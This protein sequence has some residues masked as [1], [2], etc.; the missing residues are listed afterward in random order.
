M[1]KA[2]RTLVLCLALALISPIIGCG[3]PTAVSPEM[4]KNMLKIRGYKF[5]TEDFFRGIKSEDT[6]VINGFL[7]AGMNPNSKNKD[8]MTALTYALQNTGIKTIRVLARKADIN[9]KD[10][11]DNG[12][13]H[14][15]ISRGNDEAVA[16]LLDANADVNV[17]GK[18][19]RVTNQS[20]LFAAILADNSELIEKLLKK[21]ADPN[22]ADSE[23]AF[24]LSEACVRNGATV[25]I[26]KLLIEGGAEVNKVEKNGASSLTYAAQN[27]GIDVET[28]KAIVE[29]LL[30]NGADK[31]LRD[32]TGKTALDW[33]KEIGHTEMVEILK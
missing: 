6:A 14:L 9:L 25:K 10:D 24:P 4:S 26:V 16:F 17:T 33:A 29:L 32:K 5:T 1:D 30:K 22:I 8:G 23:S 18:D 20:P 3:G 7:D 19:G 13:L 21:G 11:L 12:P 2:L 27:S 28:R 15:A 31:S